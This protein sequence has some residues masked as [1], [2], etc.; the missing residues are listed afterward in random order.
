MPGITH[1]YA[2]REMMGGHDDLIETI[3]KMAHEMETRKYWDEIQN[4][5]GGV[6]SN[7]RD[8]WRACGD[9]MYNIMEMIDGTIKEKIENAKDHD[10]FVNV[11]T[12][13]A[14]FI[15][16]N[17]VNIHHTDIDVMRPFYSCARSLYTDFDYH[18]RVYKIGAP[19]RMD[20]ERGIVWTRGASWRLIH[21]WA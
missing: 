15:V 14:I 2:M 6:Y 1:L 18:I 21:D 5:R 7:I 3:G 13:H 17:G 10:Y 8:L 20:D 12:R 11:N 4:Q 9:E 19:Y 16:K